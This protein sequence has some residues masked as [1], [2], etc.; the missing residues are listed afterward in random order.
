MPL[1]A[2]AVAGTRDLELAAM[3]QYLFGADREPAVTWYFRPNSN[4][5]YHS[6]LP[7]ESLR[8]GTRCW[9]RQRRQPVM[10]ARPD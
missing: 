4:P 8:S 1:G 3:E 7:P 10:G 2:D 9:L 5:A 6:H